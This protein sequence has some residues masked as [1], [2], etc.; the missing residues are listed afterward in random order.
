MRTFQE[1]VKRAKQYIGSEIIH[2]EDKGYIVYQCSTG[3]NYEILF[4]EVAEKRKGYGRLLIQEMCKRIKPYH[5]IFVVRREIN[6]EAGK[7]Y[8]ALGFEETVIKNLYKNENAVIG[9][10]PYDKITSR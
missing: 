7:F 2:I 8:R 3:E 5:S 9:V 1:I 10:I 6:E 4:I